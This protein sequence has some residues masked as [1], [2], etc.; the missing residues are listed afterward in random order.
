MNVIGFDNEKYLAEQTEEIRRRA[1]QNGNKLYIEFGGKLMHDMHAA[2]VLPGYDPNVK[3][4]LLQKLKDQAEILLCI[5][6]GDIE[7]KKMRAD[8]GITYDADALKLIDGLRN[9]GLLVRAVVITRF[10][11]QH[12]AKQFRARLEHRGIKVSY[13][14][15]T[16]GSPTDVETI[17][18]PEGY[19]ANEFVET[20]RPIVV[21]TGPG[22]GSGKLATC[23]TQLYPERHLGRVAGYAKFA[24]FPVWDLPLEHPVN[25][26]Y[27]AATVDLND[28]NMVD[29]Y[30][31]KA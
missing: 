19:G 5:Y 16:Q 10:S 8:F 2:R 21:V 11:G 4:R 30:H 24:T 23:L 28:S 31:L 12:A 14:Y 27:E 15:V 20:E 18:S 22:P 7:R 3:I 6:A 9:W 13:H 25:V 17:V 29:P 1:E 26:A